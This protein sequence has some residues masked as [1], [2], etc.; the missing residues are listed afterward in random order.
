VT[1]EPHTAP[2]LVTVLDDMAAA[3]GPP[4]HMDSPHA[5]ARYLLDRDRLVAA[6]R[7]RQET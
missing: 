6:T 2:E 5:R 4:E 7:N 3:L 1:T